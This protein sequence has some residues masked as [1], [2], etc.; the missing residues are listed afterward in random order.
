MDQISANNFHHSSS[1]CNA[2]HLPFKSVYI[3]LSY[4]FCHFHKT[5]ITTITCGYCQLSNLFKILVK[6]RG[7]CL[8]YLSLL[9][10][11]LKYLF[12]DCYLI[13]SC[14]DIGHHNY[15]L[16]PNWLHPAFRIITLALTTLVKFV[17]VHL[18][19]H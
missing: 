1:S 4:N 3:F 16:F 19:K 2:M 17:P 10:T 7:Y 18:S 15:F 5:T 14:Q 12:P 8:E 11:G 9:I 6:T 13:L